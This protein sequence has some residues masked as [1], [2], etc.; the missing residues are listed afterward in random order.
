MA[1]Q[2]PSRPVIAYNYKVVGGQ[3]IDAE[4]AITTPKPTPIAVP[5]AIPT[6]VLETVPEAVP[7]AIAIAASKTPETFLSIDDEDIYIDDDT[8]SSL[9][10][11]TS[12]SSINPSES[13]S[14]SHFR[15][16]LIRRAPSRRS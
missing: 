8:T 6:T 15:V 16:P 13:A 4:G 11:E 2:R 3:G 9:L 5:I 7:T 12:S 10:P 1:S 14:Q